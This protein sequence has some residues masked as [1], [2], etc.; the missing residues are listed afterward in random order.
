M[1]WPVPSLAVQCH[2]SISKKFFPSSTI[3]K[4]GKRGGEGNMIGGMGNLKGKVRRGV[5]I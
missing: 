3:Q 5:G 4:N 1:N 2:S